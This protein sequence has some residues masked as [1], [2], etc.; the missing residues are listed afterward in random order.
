MGILSRKPAFQSR[1][2]GA[3]GPASIPP[4]VRVHPRCAEVGGCEGGGGR[5]GSMFIKQHWATTDATLIWDKRGKQ[6]ERVDV[7]KEHQLHE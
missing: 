7:G 1:N 6:K 4:T 2:D 5:T 3:G